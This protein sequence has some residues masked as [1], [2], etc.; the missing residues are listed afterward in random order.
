M[1]VDYASSVMS[2]SMYYSVFDKNVVALKNEWTFWMSMNC[3]NSCEHIL[4]SHAFSEIV[5]QY[6]QSLL[7]D[8]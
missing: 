1:I 2:M 6:V 8:D 4:I 7:F 5:F 3:H